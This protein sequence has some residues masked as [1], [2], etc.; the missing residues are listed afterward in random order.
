MTSQQQQL[1]GPYDILCGRCKTSF[2]NIG[3]RRFR[4]TISLNL[5]R[6][7]EADTKQKK[8]KLIIS[9]AQE[10][11]YNVG[12]R[13]LKKNRMGNGYIELSEKQ[14]REKIGHALRDYAVSQQQFTMKELK[15]RKRQQEKEQQQEQQIFIEIEKSMKK[16]ESSYDFRCSVSSMEPITKDIFSSTFTKQLESSLFSLDQDDVTLETDP[17]ALFDADQWILDPLPSQLLQL[18]E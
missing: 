2:N 9:I 18:L 17:T 10:L 1:L 4:V 14:A 16:V 15:E 6:Y 12:A 11:K 8:T 7:L 3:N 13:F 5:Q